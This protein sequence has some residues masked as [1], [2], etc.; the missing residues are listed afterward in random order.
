VANNESFNAAGLLPDGKATARLS[1]RDCFA[2]KASHITLI[3][4][5]ADLL[6]DKKLVTVG[7]N[8]DETFLKQ[9]HNIIVFS[10]CQ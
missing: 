5:M 10:R 1:G 3:L 2:A 9:K 6:R 4:G 7:G 8:L